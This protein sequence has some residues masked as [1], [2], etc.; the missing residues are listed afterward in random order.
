MSNL[1]IN[2]ESLNIKT[3]NSE[4]ISN[5]LTSFSIDFTALDNLNN[6]VRNHKLEKVSKIRIKD[7]LNE[8]VTSSPFSDK[9]LTTITKS[10]SIEK[11][12]IR[13]PLSINKFREYR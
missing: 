6:N 4:K 8:K 11:L 5:K 10:S 13:N 9:K 1:Q 7:Y 3:H 12:S 2:F